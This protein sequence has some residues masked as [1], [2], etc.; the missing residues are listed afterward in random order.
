MQTS[1]K[2][3]GHFK[4]L[5]IGEH[6]Q[7]FYCPL[8][9]EKFTTSND[10]APFLTNT[11]LNCIGKVHRSPKGLKS[12]FAVPLLGSRTL[13]NIDQLKIL[14]CK[15]KPIVVVS[16]QT[17]C[18]KPFFYRTTVNS[19]QPL[20]DGSFS[21]VLVTDLLVNVI[22]LLRDCIISFV[23]QEDNIKKDNIEDN[24]GFLVNILRRS[25]NV[26]HSRRVTIVIL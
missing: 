5:C 23:I 9:F 12:N 7:R 3:L 4:P 8:R 17:E 2:S 22:S 11:G 15:V 20:V 25:S 14:N 26:A 18:H 19:V 10:G 24:K 6:L 16:G 21:V 1:K 13:N